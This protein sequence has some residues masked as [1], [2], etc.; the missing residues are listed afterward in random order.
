MK[1]KVLFVERQPSGAVSIERVFAQI[2]KSLASDEFEIE[3]QKLPYGYGLL[4][5]LKN[6][7][8]FRKRPADIYHITGDVH[9]I[10][11]RLPRSKTVLTIH[12]LV[13]LQSKSRFRRWVLKLLFLDLPVKKIKYFTTV[14]TATRDEVSGYFPEARSK[15]KVIENP[16]IAVFT[17][18]PEKPFDAACPTILQIGTT[19]NKN[20]LMLIEAIVEINCTLRIIGPLNAKIA[21]ALTDAGIRYENVVGVGADQMVEEYRNADIVTFCSTYEGFGLPII[22][23]QAMRKPVITSDLSPMNNVAGGGAELV[24][25]YDVFSIRTAMTKVI[26]DNEHRSKLVDLGTKNIMRFRPE[27]IAAEYAGLYDQIL[28]KL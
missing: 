15:I 13:F 1:K 17:P 28:N 6:L 20:L 5:I 10:A 2:A 9:Y 11:M 25:P 22:E 19:P 23:A 16:L 26:N 24:D 27:K 18:C 8:F 4:N 14:S 12:D 7:L 3:V 21:R